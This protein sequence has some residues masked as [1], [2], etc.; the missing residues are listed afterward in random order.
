ML[1]TP[2]GLRV[3]SK[4]IVNGN[5]LVLS[6]CLLASLSVVLSFLVVSTLVLRSCLLLFSSCR[7]V[8][9]RIVVLPSYLLPYRKG[10]TFFSL[11]P[12]RLKAAP[13]LPGVS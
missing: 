8:F 11:S 2:R 4:P 1:T 5:G 12:H 7:V 13:P 9:Y 3:H 6:A 10:T